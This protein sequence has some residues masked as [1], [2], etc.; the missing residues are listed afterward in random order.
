MNIAAVDRPQVQQ[1]ATARLAWYDSRCS[2][3]TVP[4]DD[5]WNPPHLEYAMSVGTRLSPDA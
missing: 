5:V 2:G 4:A 3:P 1:V